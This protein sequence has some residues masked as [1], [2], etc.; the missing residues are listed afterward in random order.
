MF[1]GRAKSLGSAGNKDTG[2]AELLGC[3]IKGNQPS[4][5]CLLLHKTAEIL[6][7]QEGCL[8]PRFS[9]PF[10]DEA[11]PNVIYYSL[12]PLFLLSRGFF[13]EI[14]HRKVT[15]AAKEK[16]FQFLSVDQRFFL[17]C[18]RRP[19]RSGERGR[20]T[21]DPAIDFQDHCLFLMTSDS[22]L[23]FVILSVLRVLPRLLGED[24]VGA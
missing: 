23:S 16:L 6:I 3:K 19:R 20:R 18:D 11:P 15:T 9:H 13:P 12:F 24:H 21:I 17:D 5:S 1:V 8:T 7:K 22:P 14:S 2:A 10:T 4:T